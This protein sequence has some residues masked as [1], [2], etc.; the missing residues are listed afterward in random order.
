MNPSDLIDLDRGLIDRRIFSDPDIYRRE[1]ENIFARSWLYLGHECQ[2]KDVGDFVTTYMGEDPVLV[3]RGS[4]GQLR[5]FLN[6][7]RH[8]G[9][10]I[11]RMDEGNANHFTCAYHGWTYTHDGKLVGVPSYKEFWFEELN[12]DEWGLVPVPHVDSYKGLVFGNLDPQAPP[13]LDYLG[14][15][16]WYLD[17]MLDRQAGGTEVIGGVQKWIVSA[18]WKFAAEN[19]V[20]DMYHGSLTHA[21]AFKVGFGGGGNSTNIVRDT[22]PLGYQIALPG[23]H[24]L[25]SGWVPDGNASAGS[26][27]D[28]ADFYRD[29]MPDTEQRLGTVRARHMS[30]VHGTVFPNLS[31]LFGT[32]TLRVWHPK[33]PEKIE[34]WA[35][36]LVERDAPPEIKDAIRLSC[37]RRFS[38]AGTWE[39][40]DADNWMQA[41]QASRGVATRRVRLNYQ[42]GLGHEGTHDALRGRIGP[43][44]SDTCQRNFYQHW[45]QQLAE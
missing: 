1:L 23:G 38:P 26:V 4:D 40:D 25:G 33:G 3:C 12:R 10:R 30:P 36:V 34:V 19:F 11:C 13:L 39:Q 37:L 28:I 15:M 18:N 14:D 44:Y 7:C 29:I 21:S 16:A 27:A 8:R 6:T 20:G 43:F 5:A 32:R 41:T 17:L 22:A 2:F 35:W 9:N 45:A 42:M 31:F 24:G